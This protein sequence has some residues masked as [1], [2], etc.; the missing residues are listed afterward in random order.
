[1]EIMVVSAEVNGMKVTAV[2]RPGIAIEGSGVLENG[3]DCIDSVVEGVEL[4]EGNEAVEVIAVVEA[5][6]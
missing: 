3:V 4:D 6:D 5:R 1:M 2:L